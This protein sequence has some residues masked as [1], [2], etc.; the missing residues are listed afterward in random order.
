MSFTIPQFHIPGVFGWDERKAQM[1][2]CMSRG[3]PSMKEQSVREGHLTLACYGPSLKRTY[4][5]ISGPVLSVSGAHDFL[6]ERG[7]IPDWHAVVDPR[8]DNAKMLRHANDHTQYLIASVC[9]PSVFDA[10]EGRKVAIWHCYR[11]AM[12]ADWIAANDPTGPVVHGGSTIGMRSLELAHILGFR[13]VDIHG[14]DS[15]FDAPDKQW[16]GAHSGKVHDVTLVRVGKHPKPF[17]TSALMIQQARELV[18]FWQSRDIKIRVR[19]D[20][21]IAAML[22]Q[23]KRLDGRTYEQERM[24]KHQPLQR[25]A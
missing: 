11:D 19:G 16:A 23:S 6:C 24:T 12:D 7:R 17:A 10:L 2:S 22:K 1:D 25:A 14:M 5:D 9:H 18:A 3:L 21:M 20:G 13:A 8:E 15:C 4:R